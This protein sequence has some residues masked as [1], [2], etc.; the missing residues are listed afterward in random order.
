[1]C[2][3]CVSVCAQYVQAETKQGLPDKRSLLCVCVT[4]CNQMSTFEEA[5]AMQI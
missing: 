5:T 3:L 4:A 1:M 2:V